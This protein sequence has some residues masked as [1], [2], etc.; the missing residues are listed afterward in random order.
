MD[1][2]T[3]RVL[4][5]FLLLLYGLGQA[6]SVR[7]ET[8]EIKSV[9]STFK[10]ATK[11]KYQQGDNAAWA[12]P[13][14][15]DAGWQELQIDESPIKQGIKALDSFAWYRIRLRLPAKQADISYENLAIVLGNLFYGNYE[16]YANGLLITPQ[17][18]IY[19]VGN[20]KY[21]WP[22]VTPLPAN[23]IDANG[24]LS[25]A[26]RVWVLPFYSQRS[27]SGFSGGLFLIGPR[28]SLE[29][30]AKLHRNTGLYSDIW[31]LILFTIFALVGLYHLLIY[32]KLRSE[33]DYLY[34]GFIALFF[35]IQVLTATASWTSL[36]VP[37]INYIFITKLIAAKLT[38]IFIMQFLWHFFARPINKW[39]RAFQLLNL[40][41]AIVIIFLPLNYVLLIESYSYPPLSLLLLSLITILVVQES[42][43]GNPEARILCIG[44]I[45]YFAT[46]IGQVLFKVIIVQW[47]FAFNVVL[48]A[49]VIA[50][51]F[52]RVYKDLNELNR[53]LEKK[54]AERTSEVSQ[55]NA[56][57]QRR[58]EEIAH[59]NQELVESNQRA[60]RIFSALAEALPGTVLDNKYRL[61]EIIGS[62]GF[63]AVYRATHL[64]MQR[65]I[66]VKIFK[67]L[68]GN[69]S[70]ESLER[71]C[72]EAVTTSR[73]NH[74]NAVAILDSG[75]SSD[76]IAYLVMELLNGHTLNK[77]LQEK[78]VLSVSRTL[79]ILLPVCDVLMKAHEL[80]LVHRDI[81]P[82]NIFLHQSEN[83]ETVKL[84]DFGLAKLVE[85]TGSPG[86]RDLT[87]T[88]GLVGTPTYMSPER[89]DCKPYDGRSDIYSLGVVAY[90]M[91]SGLLPFRATESG[92]ASL[93]I[94]HLTKTPPP[95]SEV[96]STI[97][98][99]LAELV[100]RTLAKKPEQRPTAQQLFMAMTNLST[101][102]ILANSNGLV[103]SAESASLINKDADFE[104]VETMR[105]KKDKSDA[106]GVLNDQPTILFDQNKGSNIS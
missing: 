20:I 62:G 37:N 52:A 6:A 48:M 15:D 42:W 80:G 12:K 86:I 81:K 74:P 24:S 14:F 61:D 92:I 50:N 4:S 22:E 96:D 89:I 100:M 18:D 34:Y 59:K 19:A 98:A 55:K 91:L 105:I 43:R 102:S 76:G 23:L 3:S 99:E 90:Q 73:I 41:N 7:A 85:N 66:A 78:G 39:L 104:N 68:P 46:F 35:S 8:V 95:L 64:A 106:V 27:G 77:E 11:W 67:P 53:S 63:G 38:S 21:P 97:P 31:G 9:E 103:G 60:D 75:I 49:I 45:C 58:I 51:R 17:K 2:R 84:V 71:F 5:F 28:S 56:E 82:D 40:V 94:Q 65:Q 10:L 44:T 54:V 87:A 13:D 32:Y 33:R 47:A 88:G 69:D 72:L 57:L 79:E 26:V 70:P 101:E 16:I 25:L 30:A 1:K 83:G 93:F 36:L 29:T